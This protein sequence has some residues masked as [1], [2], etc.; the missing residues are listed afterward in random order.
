MSVL[1]SLYRG[2]TN[3]ESD[4]LDLVRIKDLEVSL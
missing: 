2:R 3:M 1:L 4:R